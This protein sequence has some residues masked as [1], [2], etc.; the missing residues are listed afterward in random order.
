LPSYILLP[1]SHPFAHEEAL[2]LERIIAEPFILL[3]LP[4]T[5][6]YFVSIFMKENLMPNIFARSEF[7]ETV[8][9]YVASGFGYSLSTVRPKNMS[10][11]NGKPLAYVPLEG[12]FKPMVLGLA[13]LKGIRK[14]R[15]TKA[16][17]EHC[18]AHISTG[19][20]PGMAELSARHPET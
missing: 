9:S 15:A 20:L 12:N 3:D 5:R 1:A 18:R 8:R 19:K 14:T 2:A 13:T 4:L 11:L 10:A 17:E 7:P 6:E 16:F